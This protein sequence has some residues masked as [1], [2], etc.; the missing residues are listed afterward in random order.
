MNSFLGKAARLKQKW[1]NQ[2]AQAAPE[3][4]KI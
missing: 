4:Q 3:E 2:Q 1:A